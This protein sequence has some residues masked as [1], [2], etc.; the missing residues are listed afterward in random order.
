MVNKSVHKIIS[1]IHFIEVNVFTMKSTNL[2]KVVGPNNSSRGMVCRLIEATLLSA[3]IKFT[4]NS[5]FL[6]SVHRY[7]TAAKANSDAS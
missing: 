6:C 3:A 1:V 5:P 7:T 4:S 2:S